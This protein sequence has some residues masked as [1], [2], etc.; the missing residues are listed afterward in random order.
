M[1]LLPVRVE[2]VGERQ[3]VET[4]LFF[5]VVLLQKR[6]VVQYFA[7]EFYILPALN[8]PALVYLADVT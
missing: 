6:I 5:S 4:H 1:H 2:L 8:P 7:L 3:A